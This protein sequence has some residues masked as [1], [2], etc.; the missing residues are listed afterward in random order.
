MRKRTHAR[1]CAL[2]ILYQIDVT[3]ALADD[4]LRNFWA[5]SE[6][7]LDV[8]LKNFVNTL[9][10]GTIKNLN[11]LDENISHFALNW[12][13]HRMPVIDRNILRLAAFEL[14]YLSDI[15]PKV[16][17]NEAI[18]LAKKYGDKDSGKFVNA[19]LDKIK[20]EKVDSK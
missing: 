11:I 16:S 13:L 17:I 2:K 10:C 15:P 9:V 20:K 3:D 1:E 18:E 14:L 4:A 6:E 5:Y 7:S 12:Q 19:V 8:E